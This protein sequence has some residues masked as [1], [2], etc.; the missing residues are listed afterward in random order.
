MT[1]PLVSTAWLARHLGDADLLVLDASWRMPADAGDVRADYAA[2]H[3]PGAV[4][5]DIDAIADRASDLPHML[6][7]PQEFAT[8]M[9]RLGVA[10][11]SRVVAYDSAGVFSAPRA[12][13]SLRAMGHERVS[14]LDGGLPKWIAEGRPVEQGW[15]EAVHGDF[16]AAPRR[17]LVRDLAAVRRALERGDEQL[18]DARAA[19]RFRGEAPE[20]RSGLRPGH[21]PGALNLPWT[22]LVQADGTLA[23]PSL[24][25]KA[26]EAAGVGLDRPIVATCGSGLSACILALALACLGE[27]DAAVYDGS[28]SEW[29]GRADC[30]VATGA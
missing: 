29:A 1:A 26:F 16:R 21:M 4:F 10:T 27:P 2:R 11:H 6:P 19:P 23:P 18:V 20:P 22:S 7:S 15:R 5:F 24:L 8:A 25:E 14:V 3:V 30:A 17:E 13:W 12:W 28:W 9:R